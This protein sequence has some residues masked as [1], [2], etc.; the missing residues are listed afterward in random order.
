M[1]DIEELEKMMRNAQ[2]EA[3]LDFDYNPFDGNFEPAKHYDGLKE[4]MV[5]KTGSKG[6]GY[7][8][9]NKEYA[10]KKQE[11]MLESQGGNTKKPLRNLKA[12]YAQD[13]R[14]ISEHM[15]IVKCALGTEAPDG[16]TTRQDKETIE[17]PPLR[18]CPEVL[19]S[20]EPPRCPKDL[21]RLDEEEPAA[22][23]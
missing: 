11:K 23:P 21:V 7:Y 19:F 9:D 8:E 20:A 5:F 1:Q 3:Q 14:W 15:N 6:T 16:S 10:D 4:G 13:L 2:F 17:L 12:E 22:C 18:S